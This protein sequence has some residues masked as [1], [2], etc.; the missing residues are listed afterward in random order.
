M[1]TWTPEHKTKVLL[2]PRSVVDHFAQS[3]ISDNIQIPRALTAGVIS[4]CFQALDELFANN[5][6]FK[7]QMDERS[8]LVI[9]NINWEVVAWYASEMRK[10]NPQGYAELVINS[11]SDATNEAPGYRPVRLSDVFAPTELTTDV[12]DF[13]ERSRCLPMQLTPPHLQTSPKDIDADSANPAITAA[14]LDIDSLSD[15]TNEASGNSPVRSWDVSPHTELTTEVQHLTERR[16]CLLHI[17]RFPPPKTTM[18]T[19][20]THPSQQQCQRKIWRPLRRLPH[21]QCQQR[22]ISPFRPL[23]RPPWLLGLTISRRSSAPFLS[24]RFVYSV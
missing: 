9:E 22:T 19:R 18:Q 8:R 7:V 20:L 6:V 16:K 17:S 21:H 12:E 11:P 14:E 5:D 15:T 24:R 10:A 4:E 23:L 2:T 13:T 1:Y 3:D